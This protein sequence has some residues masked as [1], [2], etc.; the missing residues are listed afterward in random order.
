MISNHNQLLTTKCN[1]MLMIV[2][3]VLKM[4][5]MTQLKIVN[6]QNRKSYNLKTKRKLPTKQSLTSINFNHRNLNK[7][8]LHSSIITTF[9]K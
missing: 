9:Q 5:M 3:I 8:S 6:L 4:K 2:K 1:Q 7:Q